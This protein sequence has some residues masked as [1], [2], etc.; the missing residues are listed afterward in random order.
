MDGIRSLLLQLDGTA[1]SSARLDFARRLALAH[2]ARLWAL[3][4]GAPPRR[5]VQL[6]LS[7]SPAALLQPTP[8]SDMERVR[9]LFD[10]ANALGGPAMQWLDPA[11][12]AVP[13]FTRQA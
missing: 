3:F 13:A 8:W 9:A 1:P 4:A 6:A 10:E 2:G 5:G 7:E 11:G 12:D